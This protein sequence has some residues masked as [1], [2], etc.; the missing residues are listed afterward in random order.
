MS[1]EHGTDVVGLPGYGATMRLVQGAAPNASS[2]FKPAWSKLELFTVA[3][4]LDFLRPKLEKAAKREDPEAAVEA[5]F[6][7]TLGFAL[8]AVF[9]D[10]ENNAYIE[11]MADR[12]RQVAEGKKIEAGIEAEATGPAEDIPW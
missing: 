2:M 1:I 8:M 11:E 6:E 3:A 5:L 4:A 10:R 12:A 7:I 9:A